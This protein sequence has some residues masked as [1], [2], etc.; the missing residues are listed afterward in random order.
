MAADLHCKHGDTWHKTD[1]VRDVKVG[2]R[3]AIT[4]RCGLTT[5]SGTHAAP[6]DANAKLCQDAHCYG[7]PS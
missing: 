5:G 4:T 2:G 1:G 6:I 7:G 3:L